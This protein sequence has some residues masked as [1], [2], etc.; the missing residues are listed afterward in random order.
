MSA[1]VRRLLF[2]DQLGQHWRR[3]DPGCRGY[4]VSASDVP[5]ATSQLL[6]LNG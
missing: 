2:A 4:F 3:H 6:M 1:A 5:D